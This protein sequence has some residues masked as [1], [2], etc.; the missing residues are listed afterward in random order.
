MI[1][2]GSCDSTKFK[3][4]ASAF[5][6]S[7][8]GLSTFVGSRSLEEYLLPLMIQALNDDEEFVVSRVLATLNELTQLELFQKPMVRDLV[9][10]VTPFLCHSN[11]W[12][13]Q[14]SV[15]FINLVE[16]LKFLNT[17]TGLFNLPDLWCFLYPTIR[18]TLRCDISEFSSE[19]IIAALKPPVSHFY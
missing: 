17:C 3:L 11:P 4:I 10:L 13:R 12:L 8:V 19:H 1:R 9:S 16:S 2:I 6:E 7:T 18:P 5:F 14:G 15:F